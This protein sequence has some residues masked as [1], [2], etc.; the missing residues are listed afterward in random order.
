MDTKDI[1][2][3]A[4]DMDGTLLN[5]HQQISP[6]NLQA[7]HQ[8]RDAGIHLAICSGRLPGDIAAFAVESGLTD[9]ALLSLNGAYCLGGPGKAAFANHV[10]DRDVL[11]RLHEILAASGMTYG[12]FA[13]NTIA[14][15]EG[16]VTLA[17]A[18]WFSHMEGPYAPKLFHGE[19]GLQALCKTGVNK[20]TCIADSQRHMDDVLKRIQALPQL[21][22]FMSWPLNLEIMPHGVGKG[23]AVAELTAHLDLTADQVMTLGDYDNDLSMIS[24]AGLGVAMGNACQS[25]KD[26]ARYVTLTNEEDGVACA[27]R[28]YA[29]K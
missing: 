9:C 14:V 8:A 15:F 20:L 26:A 10:L 2:L 27:I 3:I 24:Y 4:M 7:L 28:R 23:R 11:E 19:S 1:R 5:N 25:V 22:L 16:C 29:L 17:D 13:Q 12:Y 18:Y 21:D 6:S